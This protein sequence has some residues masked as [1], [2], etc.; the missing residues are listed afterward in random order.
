MPTNK[1]YAY[2]G[3][4]VLVDHIKNNEH[5]DS[6]TMTYEDFANKINDL[7]E[8]NSL[9]RQYTGAPLEHI[10]NF[11]SEFDSDSPPITVL[12]VN[13]DTGFPND[14]FKSFYEGFDELDG[15][16]KHRVVEEQTHLIK[17]YLRAGKLDKFLSETVPAGYRDLSTHE[18]DNFNVAKVEG[19]TLRA[20]REVEYKSRDQRIVTEKKKKS[21]YIC[22]CCDFNFRETYGE[23]GKEY[24]ECHHIKPLA[25][26]CKEGEKVGLEDLAALCANCHRMIHRLL[27][28]DNE[29]YEKN[30][31]SSMDDL[32]KLIKEQKAK[33]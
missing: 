11:F 28:S 24:I 6:M 32:K 7:D 8:E 29:K 12:I 21:G 3:I 27:I 31:P 2:Y 5:S 4:V 10:G 22:E 18:D 20:H 1:E 23:L 30:Y 13:K 9:L 33:S 17:E 26:F 15:S 19:A 25:D 14:S 16:S